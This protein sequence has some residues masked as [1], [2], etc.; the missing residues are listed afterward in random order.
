M[1]MQDAVASVFR[2]YATFSGRARRAEYWWFILFSIIVSTGLGI[3]D[4]A[5][6]GYTV[7]TETG[8][9]MASFDLQSV[10]VFA[11]IW[12]LATFLPSLA[13]AVRRL[14]DIGRSGWWLLLVLLPL[15]GAIIL[16]VWFATR[17]TPATNAHGPDPIGA[18]A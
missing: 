5:L 6:F 2:N 1:N 14:H 11:P 10:G 17:G 15:I 9:G 13:V 8:E 7:S 18:A 16:I 4:A 3:L 12:S